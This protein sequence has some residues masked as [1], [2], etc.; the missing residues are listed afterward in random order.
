M[1]PANRKHY[2][3]LRAELVRIEKRLAEISSCAY[4]NMEGADMPDFRIEETLYSYLAGASEKVRY[5]ANYI[6]RTITP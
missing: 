6:K 4:G 3:K 2:K 1:H 5:A